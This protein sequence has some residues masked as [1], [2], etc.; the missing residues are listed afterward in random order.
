MSE[1]PSGN[2]LRDAGLIRVVQAAQTA[3][4]PITPANISL[5][6]RQEFG[7]TFTDVTE[8]ELAECVAY[9]G[10]PP[11]AGNLVSVEV[12]I[13]PQPEPEREP[14]T[15]TYNEAALMVQDAQQNLLAARRELADA[16][17]AQKAARG[18]LS[19]AVMAWQRGGA[20]APTRES[21]Q[22]DYIASEQARKLAG[23]NARRMPTPGPSVID[24]HAAYSAGGDANTFARK[25]MRHGSH[26]RPIFIDG[27]WQR[28]MK[29]GSKVV[30]PSEG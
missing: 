12:G 3:G 17:T 11:E 30:V 13:E 25:Q 24:Q 16:M 6:C 29:R 27:K 7:D 4:E 9:M 2:V 19:V 10:P 28:P 14:P 22:R 8:G 18:A 5:H 26:H 21:L 20:P 1:Y 15:M 23:V